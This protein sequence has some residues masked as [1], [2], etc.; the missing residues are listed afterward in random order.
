MPAKAR[1]V[2]AVE[3]DE[4]APRKLSI[5]EAAEAGD[6]RALLVSMRA[7]IALTADN[8]GCPPRDLA[9]LTRRLDEINRQIQALDAAARQEERESAAAS[10]ETWDEE[11][12]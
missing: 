9:S 2:R 3:P 4:R 8:E 12:L 10:D 1:A 6:Q 11:A 7:R 5:S